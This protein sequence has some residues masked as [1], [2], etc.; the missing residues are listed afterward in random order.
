MIERLIPAGPGRVARVRCSDRFDGDFRF[1][2][3]AR[4]LDRRR[5]EFL[6]GPWTWLRQMHGGKVVVV[7]SPG[8]EAGRPADGAVTRQM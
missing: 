4:E 5:Q 3:D 8:A 1:D 2:G 7:E 6:D